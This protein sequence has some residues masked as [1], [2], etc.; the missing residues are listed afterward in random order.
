MSTAYR[1]KQGTTA[2]ASEII[3][4]TCMT[5]CRPEFVQL[6]HKHISFLLWGM[7]SPGSNVKNWCRAQRVTWSL[8]LK[9]SIIPPNTDFW[10]LPKLKR[11]VFVFIFWTCL[12]C[13]IWRLKTLHLSFVTLT[14]SCRPMLQVT[15]FSY[16]VSSLQ[17]RTK[18]LISPKHVLSKSEKPIMLVSCYISRT[19]CTRVYF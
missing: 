11:C 17:S 4:S 14:I 13:I 9:A 10:T 1:K 19:V 8:S 2:D 6:K 16:V 12:L 5:A 15:T 3:I 18:M 7:K